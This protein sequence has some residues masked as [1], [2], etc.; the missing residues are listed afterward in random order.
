VTKPTKYEIKGNLSERQI[1]ADIATFMG[2]CTPVGMKAFQLL[3]INEQTTGADRFFDRG[4]AIYMQ[5]KKSTGLKSTSLV[6]PSSRKGRSA[7]EGIREFRAR[8]NLEEDPSLFFQLR[9]KAEMAND[10]QHNVLLSYERAPWSRAIYVAPLLLDKLTYSAV[11]FNSADRFYLDPFYY[12]LQL[13]IHQNL[14]ISR[15]G[16]IP[17]LREHVSIPPHERVVD[18]H[19]YFAYSVTGTDISWH[20]PQVIQR[21]PSRLSDFMVNLLRGAV[22]DKEA[23]TSLESLSAQTRQIAKDLGFVEEV[24]REKELPMEFFRRHAKWLRE[25]YEIRQLL[26]L[27]NADELAKL[28]P[29]R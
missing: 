11:L 17:F 28:S 13:P 7:L 20:S 10:L 1:E 29:I 3:D 15:L 9:K 21:E 2:W 26:L 27:G 22:E 4:V 8:A 18:H 16:A 24:G 6:A 5:F 12:E 25:T 19:H 14:W 23:M